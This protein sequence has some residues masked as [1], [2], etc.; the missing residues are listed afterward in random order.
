MREAGGTTGHEP[1]TSR[2][3]K[4]FSVEAFFVRPLLALLLGANLRGNSQDLVFF[5]R[6]FPLSVLGGSEMALACL[7][8]AASPSSSEPS[9]SDPSGSE[10]MSDSV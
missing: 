8:A 5:E 6:T 7:V 2:V 3:G 1:P 9:L 4:D 10:A